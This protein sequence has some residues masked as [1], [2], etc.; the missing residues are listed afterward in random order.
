MD[1]QIRDVGRVSVFGI[2][3]ITRRR[4]DGKRNRQENRWAKGGQTDIYEDRPGERQT[5]T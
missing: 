4:G 2:N 1:V 3:S 5:V